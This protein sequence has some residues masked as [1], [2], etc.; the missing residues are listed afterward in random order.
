MRRALLGT[1]TYA[2]FFAQAGAFLPIMAVSSLR[3]RGDPTQRMPGRWM[4]RFGRSTSRA[5]PLWKFDVE[6]QAPADI[7]ERGY[8]VVSNHESTADPFLLSFLPW[9]MRWVAKEELFRLPVLGWMMRFG[10]DIPLRRGDRES[11]AEMFRE[12]KRTLAH[13]MS[14]MMFPEGTRSPTGVL[15]EFKDGAFQL[16]IEAGVPVLPLAV[17]GTR[18]CRPKGS[19]WFGEARAI[20]KIL[21][22]IETTGL[23]ASDVPTLRERARA[24]IAEAVTPLRARTRPTSA[25]E[26]QQPHE[27]ER[28]PEPPPARRRS[29]QPES[30]TGDSGLR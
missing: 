30:A 14:I 12:A 20:V 25:E 29:A 26:H 15:G 18:T 28:Q 11:V 21:A 4:R 7:R 10:G 3:H 24:Q 27:R 13:G 17:A 8:V 16:A 2:E 1:L 19:L 9:D 6:G 22:P 5:T 23:T